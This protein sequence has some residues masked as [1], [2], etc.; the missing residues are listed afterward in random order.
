MRLIKILSIS[1]LLMFFNIAIAQDFKDLEHDLNDSVITTKITAKITRSIKLN[2]LKISV[3]THDGIVKLAGSVE[4]ATAFFEVIKI[5]KETTG[6][7][8]V[9]SDELEIKHM[10]TVFTD[11]YITAKVQSAILAAKLLDDE[12]IPLVGINAITENGV[13]TLTGELENKESI[14]TL[15]KH[16][17]HI[18]GVKQVISNLTAKEF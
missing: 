10:N 5:V 17:S 18:H 1:I 8:Y 11:V 13:V 7:K 12:T 2:P 9:N 14:L 3:S 4:N 15:L 16:I 6:V